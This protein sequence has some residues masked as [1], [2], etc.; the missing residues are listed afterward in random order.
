MNENEKRENFV[1]KIFPLFGVN[2]R[3]ETYRLFYEISERGNISFED[4]V[5]SYKGLKFPALK[6]RLLKRRYPASKGLNKSRVYLPKFNVTSKTK[7]DKSGKI[8]P[9]NVFIQ[10]LAKDS[11]L[12][13][14]VMALF[15]NAEVTYFEKNKD[16]LSD[17]KIQ[18]ATYDER[19]ENL[20]ILKEAYDFIKPCPC[21]KKALCCGYSVM[22]LGFGCPYNCEFC[23]LG[24]YQNF[25]AIMLHSNIEDFL[26]AKYI[27][28]LPKGIF[29]NARLGTGEFSDS[30][31]LDH[32]SGYSLQLIDFFKNHPAIEFEF[33]TKS[34]NVGNL[35]KIRPPKNIT[36]AWSL[37]PQNIIG[38][39]EH[40]TASLLQRLTA[41]KKCVSAGYKVAFHFDPIFYYPEWE[42]D[43][44]GVVDGI[45]SN[46]E[47]KNISWISLGTLRF[48][49]ALKKHIESR[50]PATDML[51]EEMFL[52][53]DGKLRYPDN[54]RVKIY[55]TMKDLISLK[56]KEVFVYLC[57]ENG[58]IWRKSG[59]SAGQE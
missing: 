21:T 16:L 27:A 9:K 39:Y 3:R 41:A 48:N 59:F 13:K 4:L 53:Y 5:F 22:G 54:V 57:M 15:P 30:L 28:N 2:K 25:P 17:K 55:E 56:S 23:F 33:K 37:N 35:L 46:I 10:N 31:A 42:S 29:P 50:F 38:K 34:D 43:Y 6:A 51:R 47:P 14:R 24:Q 7:I 45:F 36:V 49:P 58:E 40:G 26:D 32:I 1:S 19:N 44:A 20:V 18:N 8:N 52:G 12:G 11:A